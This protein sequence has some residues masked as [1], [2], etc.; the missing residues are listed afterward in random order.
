LT[1]KLFGQVINHAVHKKAMA[2]AIALCF[3]SPDMAH[4]LIEDVEAFIPNE[5]YA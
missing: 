5:V 4:I 3:V 2:S 1:Q